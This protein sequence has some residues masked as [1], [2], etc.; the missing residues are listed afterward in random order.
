MPPPSTTLSPDFCIITA[1]EQERD[2]VLSKLPGHRKLDRDGTDTHTYFEA[3]VPTRRSDGAIYRVLVT[4]LSGMGPIKG[5]NKANAVI[6][7]WAP[8]H[9]LLVGIAGGVEGEVELGDILIASDIADYTLGK[10]RNHELRELRWKVYQVD[11]NLLDASNN[12]ATGWE[13][14]LVCQRPGAGSPKRRIG[15]LASGGDVIDSA[16]VIVRYRADYSK[17]IGVEMEGS[18]IAAALH[19]EITRP[20]FLMIRSVSDFANGANNARVKEKWREYACHAAAAYAIGLLRDGPVTANTRHSP[21]SLPITTPPRPAQPKASQA[22]SSKADE[23]AALPSDKALTPSQDQ[24]P[25][26]LQPTPAKAPNTS[27]LAGPGRILISAVALLSAIGWLSLPQTSSEGPKE[28]RKSLLLTLLDALSAPS[29]RAPTSNLTPPAVT[30]SQEGTPGLRRRHGVRAL[31]TTE[32]GQALGAVPG[33][34][35]GYVAPQ[36]FTSLPRAK[37]LQTASAGAIEVHKLKGGSIM[38]AG[39]AGEAD[40]RALEQGRPFRFLLLPTA[41]AQ[42][43]TGVAVPSEW[44]RSLN[45]QGTVGEVWL[46][47]S[48]PTLPHPR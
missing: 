20:P 27:R 38:L 37:I 18:G 24:S 44:V 33:G 47:F 1:L 31:Q 23:P 13:D 25:I 10:E 39:Y 30:S 19:E 6:R 8:R 35:F 36:G 43:Q 7:Q 11:S 41:T 21:E 22:F 48:V 40:A 26:S 4:C 3:Q 28:R 32:N 5:A 2:A 14:L 45:V 12:F 29:D 16:G 9:V 15:L 46:E 17:L 34:V 42:A